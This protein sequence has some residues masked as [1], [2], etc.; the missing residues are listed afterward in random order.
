MEKVVVVECEGNLSSTV[1]S[2]GAVID[3]VAIINHRLPESCSGAPWT[4]SEALLF[5]AVIQ[6]ENSIRVPQLKALVLCWAIS[7][8]ELNERLRG[9]RAVYRYT[10]NRFIFL[11]SVE[12]I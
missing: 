2:L 3:W 4:L 8:A 11:W 6:F 7:S 10:K 5:L 1:V 9:E 12:S